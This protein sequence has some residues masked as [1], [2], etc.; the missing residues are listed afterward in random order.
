[1]RTRSSGQGGA[2]AVKMDGVARLFIDYLRYELGT[3]AVGDYF[4]LPV[5]ELSRSGTGHLSRHRT[6]SAVRRPLRMRLQNGCESAGGFVAV[7]GALL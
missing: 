4:R 6:R 7:L 2:S 3:T 5:C 1:M